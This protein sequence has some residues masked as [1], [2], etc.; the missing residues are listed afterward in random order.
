MVGSPAGL[1][2]GRCS[3]TLDAMSTR[4]DRRGFTLIEICIVLFLVIMLVSVA[5]P[6]LSGQLARRHLQEASDRLD[7]LADRARERSVAEGRPY[8]LIWQKNGSI[9][10]YPADT[11]EAARN[12]SGPVSALTPSGSNERYT[13]IR[14]ASLTAQPAP[15]WTFWPTGNCEPVTVRYQGS[16]G[17]WEAAY[18]P[19][20]GRGV[21]SK[22]LAQ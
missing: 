10:L 13:L 3:G 6:S 1:R 17:E 8:L 15:E 7:E 22:F 9:A 2:A 11:T 4:H 14:G 21:F 12:K 20:S 18:S 5:M 16:S 19:L